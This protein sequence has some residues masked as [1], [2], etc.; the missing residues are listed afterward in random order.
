MQCHVR[1]RR[2][3]QPNN[4]GRTTRK[5]PTNTHTAKQKKHKNE[6]RVTAASKQQQP[7]TTCYYITTTVTAF[8]NIIGWLQ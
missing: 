7:S 6:L 4:Q 3:A 5:M 1:C 8:P 2:R